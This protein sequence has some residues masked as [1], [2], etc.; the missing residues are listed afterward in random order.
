M[1]DTL[2]DFLQ[3]LGFFVNQIDNSL[4][5]LRTTK[6]LESAGHVLPLG[7]KAEESSIRITTKGAY[8]L[9]RFPYMFV[10]Y[11]AISTDLLILDETVR[12]KIIDVSDIGD[13]LERSEI[14]L[15][16]LEDCYSNLNSVTSGV[17]W[18]AMQTATENDIN[19][20]KKK[21]VPVNIV[22]QSAEE[23]ASKSV[24]LIL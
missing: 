1:I 5:A 10:Y 11:D 16:Y 9:H 19:N 13:R 17:D 22:E 7:G 14:I 4:G 23:L 18:K 12:S 15:S 2:Y 8:H 24:V 3:G 6:L 21:F 20:I